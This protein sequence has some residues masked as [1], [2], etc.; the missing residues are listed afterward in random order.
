MAKNS[1]VEQLK[2]LPQFKD[3]FISRMIWQI[4]KIDLN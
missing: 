3:L 1:N 2:L 4:Q